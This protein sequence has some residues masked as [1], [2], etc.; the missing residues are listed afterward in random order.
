MTTALVLGDLHSNCPGFLLDFFFKKEKSTNF[1][2][3]YKTLL[4]QF[5]AKE[6]Q[7]KTWKQG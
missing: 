6:A 3:S 4:V 7:I 1:Q 2:D 5:H